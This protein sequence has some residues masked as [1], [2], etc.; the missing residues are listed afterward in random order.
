LYEL[1]H[2]ARQN[3]I[4]FNRA[5]KLTDIYNELMIKIS[6][7]TTSDSKA[8]LQN[9][10][11]T[12]KDIIQECI[13]D[14]SALIKWLYE[15]QGI[16][17]FDAANRFFVVLIDINHLSESW[18]LKR[19]KKLLSEE[20]NNYLNANERI[21]FN[22]LKISFNWLDKVYNTYSTALFIVLDR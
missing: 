20:I 7:D 4:F 12:R 5:D 22:K 9:L 15:E 17:R 11:K 14:P 8:F 6:E 19:N 1:T 13:N 21:D 10:N 2:Y 18:K 16:R 3:N